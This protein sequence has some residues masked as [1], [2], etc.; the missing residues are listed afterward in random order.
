[1]WIVEGFVQ[2]TGNRNVEDVAEDYL[3]EL[4]D[5]SLIQ[6]AHTRTDGGVKTCRIHD[7]L[8]DLCISESKEEKFLEVCSDFNLLHMSKSRRLSINCATPPDMNLCDSSNC[9]SLLD[10]GYEYDESDL[11]WL[12][13]SLWNLVTLELRTSKIKCLPKEIWMLE[14]LRHLYLGGPT[15]IP[16]ARTDD[17]A[18]RNLQVLTAS[19]SKLIPLEAH[20]GN[21][22]RRV[23]SVLGSLPY[24][25]ILKLGFHRECIEIYLLCNESSFRQLDVFE[26]ADLWISYWELGKGAMPS[27]RRLVI[28]NCPSLIMRPEELWCL[29]AL[30][31]LEVLHPS[32]EMA[33]T[34][35]G[36]QM[37]KNGCKLQVNPPLDATN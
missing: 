13:N 37:K 26:M 7:L 25:R 27:L 33:K 24:L 34:L 17:K 18:L 32:E 15:S 36:L 1:M 30:Q 28:N 9:H 4:I 29:T 14:K 21:L 11:K 31:D 12:C 20:K 35:Q 3:E 19:K 10:F 16:R 5:R 8:R 22:S 2:Q 6:V 23:T